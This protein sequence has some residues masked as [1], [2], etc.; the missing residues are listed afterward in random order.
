MRLIA[1]LVILLCGSS[2]A[3]IAS[4]SQLQT[5]SGFVDVC[6][7][8]ETQL[9]KERSDALKKVPPSQFMEEFNKAMSDRMIE[10]SMCFA[11]MRGLI[12]GWKEGHE[13][14]VAAAQFPDGWPKD[15]EKSIK[16]LPLKQL[17]AAS[18]AM[19]RDVPCEPSYV[20][21]GQERDIVLKYI[22]AQESKGNFLI[23]MA[24]TSHVTYLAFQ[25][26]FLCPAK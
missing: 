17:E 20:T 6:G 3:Q 26:A 18:A 14:G 25:E 21:Q 2:T 23:G 8:S 5:A 19:K 4:L 24:L 22:H 11:Y 15:E 9:S 16:A 12:D 13:H 7:R 1:L 10:V